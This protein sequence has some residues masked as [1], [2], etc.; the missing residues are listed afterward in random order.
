MVPQLGM[1][2]LFFREGIVPESW[3][4]EIE[5]QDVKHACNDILAEHLV[6][7]S[8]I[9]PNN[10]AFFCYMYKSYCRWIIRKITTFLALKIYLLL[11][12]HCKI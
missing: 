5:L 12:W 7:E 4:S 2:V 8:C 1:R 10:S 11:E 6:E 9:F 3:I